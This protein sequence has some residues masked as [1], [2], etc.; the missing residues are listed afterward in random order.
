M[1]RSVPWT[2]EHEP[3]SA[4]GLDIA[5]ACVFD[6]S[7]KDGRSDACRRDACSLLDGLRR[8]VNS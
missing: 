8:G 5:A 6:T 7:R 3:A 1:I 4:G 2:G